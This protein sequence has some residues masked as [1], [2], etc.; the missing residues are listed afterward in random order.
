MDKKYTYVKKFPKI[1]HILEKVI[2]FQINLLQTK[3]IL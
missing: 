3:L 2:E 1:I